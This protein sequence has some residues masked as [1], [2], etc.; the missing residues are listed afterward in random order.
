[1]PFRS[2]RAGGKGKADRRR[3]SK[4][5]RTRWGLASWN[6]AP[7]KERRKG[8]L[9]ERDSKAG[10]ELSLGSCL[11]LSFSLCSLMQTLLGDDRAAGGSLLD[12]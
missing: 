5:G 6:L 7:R 8:M 12:E 3:V 2:P 1:M 4:R 9:R 10:E 11:C